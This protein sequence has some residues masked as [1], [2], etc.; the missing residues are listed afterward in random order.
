MEILQKA[1]AKPTQQ[2]QIRNPLQKLAILLESWPNCH[3]NS[4]TFILLTTTLAQTLDRLSHHKKKDGKITIRVGLCKTSCKR[5][6]WQN[7]KGNPPQGKRAFH[8]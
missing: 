5:H 1:N 3:K 7:N 8:L 4:P 2:K 6:F